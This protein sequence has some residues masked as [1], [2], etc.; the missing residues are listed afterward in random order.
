M[1]LGG[2][3]LLYSGLTVAAFLSWSLIADPLEASSGIENTLGLS[4]SRPWFETS[5][6]DPFVVNR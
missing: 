4:R 2:K 3:A 1:Q 5:V 6:P